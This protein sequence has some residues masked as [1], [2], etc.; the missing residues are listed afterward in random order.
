M[1][2]STNK[3]IKA[4][5]FGTDGELLCSLYDSG[6]TRLSQ[7]LSELRGKTCKRVVEVSILAD[8]TEYNWY[9]VVGDRLV[10]QW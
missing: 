10:K 2:L 5:A 6:Y 3:E 7:V 9:K 8:D 1:K 4:K